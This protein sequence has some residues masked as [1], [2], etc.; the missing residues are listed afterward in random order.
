MVIIWVCKFNSLRPSD[1]YMC[2]LSDHDCSDSAFSLG[3]RHTIILNNVEILYKQTSLKFQHIHSRKC[4]WKC[5]LQNAGHI[6]LASM[7]YSLVYVVCHQFWA[8]NPIYD[9][10]G[11]YYKEVEKQQQCISETNDIWT[12]NIR[13][14]SIRNRVSQEPIDP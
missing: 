12:Y 8:V 2:R 13:N 14:W 3:R 4:G 10:T 11:T 6:V 5:H 7:C 9:N 1:I